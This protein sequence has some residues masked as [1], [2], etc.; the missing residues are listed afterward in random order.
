MPIDFDLAA[1]D[2][3]SVPPLAARRLALPELGLTLLLAPATED[4]REFFAASLVD[5][6]AAAKD[7][8][9]GEAVTVERVVDNRRRE[10]VIFAAHVVKGWEGVR[11]RDGSP[12]PFSPGAALELLERIIERAPRFWRRIESFAANVDNFTAKAIAAAEA[13]AGNSSSG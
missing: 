8:T 9:R 2:A 4:N 6:A 1:L 12:V 13:L 11:G 7:G 3:V 5:L 10:A